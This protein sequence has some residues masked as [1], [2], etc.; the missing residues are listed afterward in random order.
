MHTIDQHATVVAWIAAANAHDLEQFLSFFTEDAVLDDPSVG[1]S[2][3]GA[4]G[5]GGYFT[6]YFIGYRTT[7]TLLGTQRRG[8]ALHVDV[9]FTG[10]FP[11]G[12]VGGTFDLVFRDDRIQHVLADLS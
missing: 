4:D 1:S 10:D 12:R 11:G 3:A 9:G 8:D 6:A 5:I 2:F 7:T